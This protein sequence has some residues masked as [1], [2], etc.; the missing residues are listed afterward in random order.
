MTE[1][2]VGIK[3]GKSSEKL[4]KTW[5]KQLIFSSESFV[6]FRSK[7]QK[8]DSISKNKQI[9]HVM[10]LLVKEWHERIALVTL[11]EWFARYSSNV[12]DL[13]AIRAL[14]VIGLLFKWIARKKRAIARKIRIFCMFLT[15]FPLF[16]PKWESISFH[17]FP[18]SFE[19]ILLS[20]HTV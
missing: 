2:R 9:T 13:L 15:V 4:S 1:R 8:C 12:S 7:E 17:S 20:L 16:M 19:T 5:W 18:Q 6:F 11:Y 10:L 14:W 3:N